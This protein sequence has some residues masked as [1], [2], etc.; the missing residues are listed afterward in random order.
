MLM[1]EN[2]GKPLDYRFLDAQ[3]GILRSPK[4]SQRFEVLLRRFQRRC[5]VVIDVCNPFMS[6]QEVQDSSK[7]QDLH[8]SQLRAMIVSLTKTDDSW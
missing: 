3:D 1:W 6:L 5:R 2:D 8:A 4:M 7:L